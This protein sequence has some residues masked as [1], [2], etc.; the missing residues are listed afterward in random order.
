MFQPLRCCHVCVYWLGLSLESRHRLFLPKRNLTRSDFCHPVFAGEHRF[1]Q[2][3]S[4]TLQPV[5]THSLSGDQE[6]VTG[7]IDFANLQKTAGIGL[8]NF[9]GEHGQIQHGKTVDPVD[10][11]RGIGEFLDDDFFLQPLSEQLRKGVRPSGR[12]LSRRVLSTRHNTEGQSRVRR[13]GDQE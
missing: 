12:H 4:C 7:R 10:Q 13:A 2:D 3:F 11:H 1:A 6:Q 8:N 9:R 5:A